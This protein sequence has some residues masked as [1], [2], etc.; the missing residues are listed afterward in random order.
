M[1][2]LCSYLH[3]RAYRNR[4]WFYS[5]RPVSSLF[6]R[7]ARSLP[8]FRHLGILHYRIRISSSSQ[9]GNEPSFLSQ[10]YPAH[11]SS[12]SGIADFCDHCSWTYDRARTR[13]ALP[14]QSCRVFSGYTEGLDREFFLLQVPLQ[15]NTVLV[16]YWSLCYEVFFYLIVGILLAMALRAAKFH[17]TSTGVMVFIFA[18]SLLTVSTILWLCFSSWAIFPF[19]KWHYFAIGG[20]LYFLLELPSI[21]APILSRTKQLWMIALTSAPCAAMLVFIAMRQ[22]VANAPVRTFQSSREWSIL[23]LC[24]A[25]FLYLLR[26]YSRRIDTLKI[27]WPLVWLGS[28]SYSLYLTHRIFLPYIDMTGRM[29]K[30]VGSLYWYNALIQIAVCI[31]LGRIFY[32]FFERPF[33]SKKRRDILHAE[34]VE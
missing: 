27:L 7:T 16:V 21:Q 1:G 13:R 14:C 25:A 4:Q 11:I 32:R 31:F 30:L 23:A 6:T 29:L 18:N 34:A 22:D 19:D 9:P 20:T 8:V 12:L 24:F 5:F 33:I 15:T 2:R 3:R 17:G 28:G 10:P 26:R